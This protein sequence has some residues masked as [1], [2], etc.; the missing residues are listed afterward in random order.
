MNA[1]GSLLSTLGTLSLLVLFYILARLS[2]RFGAVIKMR[3]LYYY[4][5]VALIFLVIGYMAHILIVVA[6]LAPGNVPPWLMSPW[7]RFFLYDLSL[8]IGV[9]TGLIVT[10]RYW[11]W[12]VA[13]YNG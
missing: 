8:A 3:P 2:E 4:Y 1:I 5:Y 11:S 7:F 12:L 6:Y 10:W 9:T 13:E